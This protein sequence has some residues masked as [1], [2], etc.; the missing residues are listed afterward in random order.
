MAR[1]CR[2][3]YT[4]Y[5]HKH[6]MNSE[7]RGHSFQVRP[8]QEEVTL[9]FPGLH[10]QIS[11]KET[12]AG[13]CWPIKVKQTHALLWFIIALDTRL[14][15]LEAACKAHRTFSRAI[16]PVCPGFTSLS[17]GIMEAGL[18]RKLSGLSS[19]HLPTPYNLWDHLQNSEVRKSHFITSSPQLSIPLAIWELLN[20]QP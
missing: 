15:I 10:F 13:R 9:H 11:Q 12:H 2:Q 1:E 8:R 20:T 16:S 6:Q 5:S 14:L 7:R 19:P 18:H 4:W 17:R 3:N